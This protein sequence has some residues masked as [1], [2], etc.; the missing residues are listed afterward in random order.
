MKKKK[1]RKLQSIPVTV[2]ETKSHMIEL[3][4]GAIILIVLAVGY[5]A[6][7][8]RQQGAVEIPHTNPPAAM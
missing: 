8:P 3:I 7:P 6:L 4:G 1:V 2:P 5:F